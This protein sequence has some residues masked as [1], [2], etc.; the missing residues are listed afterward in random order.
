MRMRPGPACAEREPGSGSRSTN[1]ARKTATRLGA[2][3][4]SPEGHICSKSSQSS[5]FISSSNC[6]ATAPNCSATAPYRLIHHQSCSPETTASMWE[7]FSSW[8]QCSTSTALSFP[9]YSSSKTHRPPANS[10][11][12]HPA[13]PHQ[14][15]RQNNPHQQRRQNNPPPR[16]LTLKTLLKS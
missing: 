16:P 11:T 5:Y 1:T 4:Y 14:Q 12:V 2:S 15:R 9:T 8:W 10:R 13:P 7:P 3:I 6:S